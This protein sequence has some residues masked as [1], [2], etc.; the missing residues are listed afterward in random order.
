MYRIR[1]SERL[2]KLMFTVKAQMEFLERAV[3]KATDSSACWT[4][5]FDL[6]MWPL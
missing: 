3:D 6:V 5:E 2:D 4:P 1:L